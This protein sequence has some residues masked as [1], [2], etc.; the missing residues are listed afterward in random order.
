MSYSKNILELIGNTPL[1]KLKGRNIFAKLEYFN[2]MHSVKDRPALSMIEGAEQL[3]KLSKGGTVIE[4]TSGN[5]GIG[6][7][8]V[9]KQKGY[10]AVI[11][12]P[13][14]MSVERIKLL[15]HLGATVILTP[16]AQGMQGAVNKASEI[17]AATPNSFLASQ[18]LNPF[19]AKAHIKT[20]REIIN[21]L[22]GVIPDYLVL[23][24][25]SGGT[26]SGIG[27][28]FKKH[29][30]DIK[31]IAVEP[32]ESP[33]LSKGYYGSHGI[34]GIGANFVPEILDTSI[35]D[36]ILTVLTSDAISYARYAVTEYGT[37]V[38]ISSGAALKASLDIA[39]SHP[40]ANIV[41]L[42]PDSAER[43]LQ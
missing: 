42:F 29:Y 41:T 21:D 39:L 27:R 35:I 10:N 22:D 1:L 36:G 34:Q 31:I 43:Y 33:L 7:A 30:H 32:A 14:N 6:L 19:N 12:M 15:E 28:V 11:V 20:A 5:T 13:D 38:G 37:L 4:A 26:I 17:H 40:T 9:A 16:K 23:T 25:G 18:F 3:G 8:F 2:P 24:F